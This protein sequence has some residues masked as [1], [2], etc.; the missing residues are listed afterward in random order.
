MQKIQQQV[1]L[2]PYNTFG[3][4][5]LASQFAEFNDV[6]SLL[7]LLE[8]HRAH[9]S[10]LLL[11]G[12]G[13]N[14]LFR[15]NFEGLVLRNRLK[16]IEVLAEDD[17]TVW[18]KAGAGEIWD[19][20]VAF[21]VSKGWGGLE[22]LSLIPGC[23]G[24]SPMQNIG[25]YGAEIKDT[26]ERVDALEIATGKTV[27]F[28]KAACRF[29]YR[30]SIFKQEAR[31]KYLITA[32]TFALSKKPRINAAYGNLEKELDKMQVKQTGIADIRQA[33]IAVRRSK[34]PDPAVL[35]NAG[36]FFKNPVVT[37]AVAGRILAAHPGAPVYDAGEG[38][39]KLAAGWLIESCGLKGYRQGD[40]GVHAL[41]AL[42]LVNFGNATGADIYAL[43]EHVIRRVQET[44][45]VELE[46]E[47]NII[48]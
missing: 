8:E 42:V 18:V 21:A 43:S 38:M 47:V 28:S 48:G 27:S 9:P 33:V 10:P 17:S 44:F 19:E 22:N 41:Q 2:K 30:D 3:I 40:A 31:N 14:V 45:G 12:G 1:N 15:S 26:C 35:G 7:A 24:A 46:R 29:G 36:S 23:V 37:E 4:N 20:W 11:L 5:C 34:L 13:S 16:G 25:A 32:V 39:K 6:P